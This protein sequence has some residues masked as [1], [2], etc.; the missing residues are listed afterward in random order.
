MCVALALGYNALVNYNNHFLRLSVKQGLSDTVEL[1]RG[2]AGA[3]DFW[4]LQGYVAETR[5]RRRQIEPD[6]LF[7]DKQVGDLADLDLEV[8][9]LLPLEERISAYWRAGYTNKLA[10][11]VSASVSA[12]DMHRSR[13][14][15]NA[16]KGFRSLEVI[17]WLS[18]VLQDT[19]SPALKQLVVASLSTIGNSSPA[20]RERAEGVL[21]ELATAPNREVQ[22]S[23]VG[24]LVRLGNAAVQPWAGLSDQFRRK[25]TPN[26]DGGVRPAG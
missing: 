23:A 22:E 1:Y 15:L 13:R 21:A 6:K 24:T 17:H 8:I 2:K 3:W 19:D 25:G 14:I 11:L 7:A 10:K 16:L 4:G 9:Q 12:H 18:R 26:G 5:I 20:A